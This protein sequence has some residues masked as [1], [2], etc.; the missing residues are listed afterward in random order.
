[1]AKTAIQRTFYHRIEFNYS[2]VFDLVPSTLQTIPHNNDVNLTT[3]ATSGDLFA[4][5]QVSVPE[6]GI[7]NLIEV[8]VPQGA[9]ESIC[10]QI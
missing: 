10:C 7:V 1:M 5:D 6:K 8:L 2:V 3:D 4:W 9:S